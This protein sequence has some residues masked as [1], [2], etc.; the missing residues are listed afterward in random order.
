MDAKE[1]S[2]IRITR[3]TKRSFR[4]ESPKC[5]VSFDILL[6]RILLREK[7]LFSYSFKFRLAKCTKYTA[8]INTLIVNNKFKNYV[9]RSV[10]LQECGFWMSSGK[11]PTVTVIRNRDDYS[12]PKAPQ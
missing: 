7:L 12:G 5:V 10:L 2:R 8:M 6:G 11:N 4:G 1:A 3:V 9:E